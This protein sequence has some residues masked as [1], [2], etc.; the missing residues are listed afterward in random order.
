MAFKP[1]FDLKISKRYS[2]NE[3]AAIAAEVLDYIVERTEKGKDKDGDR[4]PKYTKQ[5][6]ELKGQGNVDLRLS[7]EMLESIALLANEKGKI[8]LGYGSGSSVAG[9]V[10]GNCVG[11]YGNNPNPAKARNFLGIEDAALEK[12]LKKY[13]LQDKEQRQ[14]RVQN[15]AAGEVVAKDLLDIIDFDF[16]I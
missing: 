12:I 9:K 16:D 14:E 4:F 7:G 1:Y 5:Y 3:R 13:P 8:R 2:E 10:E 15:V 11:S 6:S